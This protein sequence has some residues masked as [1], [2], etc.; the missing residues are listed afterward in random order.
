MSLAAL[1]LVSG[2]LFAAVSEPLSWGKPGVSVEQYRLD[3]VECGRTG[4]YLDVSGTEA[5]SVFKAASKQLDAN[6]TNL[7]GAGM[8]LS[9]P[10]P[11]TRLAAM[12]AV[13]STVNRSSRIVE[14]ARPQERM[15]EVA[16]L[17]QSK[18]DNCL[19]SRGYVQFRL[20]DPQ[21]KRLRHLHLGSPE[22]HEYLYRLSSDPAVLSAQA[23]QSGG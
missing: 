20:T 7:Q 18:V 6:E 16:M 15:R 19:R 5:A 14:G 1:G 10:N 23:T 3:A 21:R 22:R 9:D 4:Y 8:M 2:P 11:G 12:N 17:M 13:A